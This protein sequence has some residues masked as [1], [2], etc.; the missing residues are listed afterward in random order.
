MSSR[1]SVVVNKVHKDFYLS[2][3]GS[4]MSS[5]RK[6]PEVVTALAGVSLV[7]QPGESVGIL[8]K[9]GS[10][11]STLLRIIAGSESPTSGECLVSA[12][13]TLLGVSAALQKNMTGYQNIRLGL[14]AMGLRPQKVS[15]LIPQIAEWTDLE[16]AINRPIKTYSSGMVARL[17]FGIAT[18]VKAD[19][20]L[21][22]EALSTGDSTFA[23]KAK[24]RMDEFL[25]TAGTVFL[26]S[27]G[28]KTIQE[29][30]SRAIWMHEG[31]V[32]ADGDAGEVSKTYRIWGNRVATGRFDEAELILRS[33]RSRYKPPRIK[34][35]GTKLLSQ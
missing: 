13:P 34:I 5:R 23:A 29:H 9:N 25:N 11:K 1:A 3:T 2:K 24:D 35:Y 30:C 27:H 19:L 8:G 7:A 31:R 32:I 22:D 26:V 12:Q 17:K 33:T 20:L 21:V 15:A 6:N 10:G 28:A 16:D 18:S 4:P 14:L